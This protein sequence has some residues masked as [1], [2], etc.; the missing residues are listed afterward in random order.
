MTSYFQGGS[1][2]SVLRSMKVSIST[3]QVFQTIISLILH[4]HVNRSRSNV[5]ASDF[6][7]EKDE[8]SNATGDLTKE[9]VVHTNSTSTEVLKKQIK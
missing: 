5:D 2:K 6:K 7:Y 9:K 4:W 1:S 3:L 8:K